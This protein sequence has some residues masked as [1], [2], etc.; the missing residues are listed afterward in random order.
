MANKVPPRNKIDRKYKWNAESV[1]PSDEAWE[2]EIGRII[3]DIAKV[4]QYQ[5]RLAEGPALLLDALHAVDNLASR[6]Q[7]AYMY[8]GFSYNVDTTNQKAAGMIDKAQGMY[9]QVAST[10]SFLD[11]EILAIGREKLDQWMTENAKLEEY[12]Q[13]FDDLF[14]KQMHVRSA[15]VEEILGL[16][17]DPLNGASNSTSML[18]N[19]DFKFKSIKDD[20]GR[21]IDIT[22]GNYDTQLMHLPSR[23]ARKAAYN[24]Y[25]DQYLAHRNT[26]A[27]N[28]ATS[29]KAN[30][31]YMRARKHESTLAASLFNLNIPTEVFHNLI[32]TFKKN[33]PVWHRYFELRR[34]ALGVKKLAYYDMW[35]PISKRNVTVPFE[36]AVDL[37]CES[38]APM[39]KEYVDTIR[40]GTLKER[41]VDIYPNQGKGNGA[42]SWGSQGTHPFIMMSYTDEVTSMSTLA[43]ELGHSMHSYLTWKNQPFVYAHYSLFVAEVASNFH[44]AMM[45]GHLLNSN[46]DKHFKLALIEEAVGGNFFRYFFQMPTLARFELETHQRAERGEPLTADSMIALMADLFAEGLGPNFDMDRERVGM[47]W[48]TFP[49]LF[50]DYYV[51]AYATGISGAHAAAGRILRKE[52]NAVEDYLGF[53]KSGSSDYSLNVLKKAGIDLTSPKTVEETFA[54]MEGYIDRMEELLK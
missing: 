39:G 44:Q 25:M 3:E 20:K 49:H 17:G 46:I 35:A 23:K 6:A 5:G 12:K 42:F 33:L 10:V 52:P 27:A 48:A 29:I 54:V 45:R 34:K 31:F 9:G 32:D 51:Y 7:T 30:V 28:L 50:S 14:R 40:N 24:I 13:A 53:L 21:V 36:K 18:T 15:E 41:W 16:V 4:K 2:K 22:Q 1:F 43:H 38:L 26:L 11:P 37:I 8:A 47:T 19:A